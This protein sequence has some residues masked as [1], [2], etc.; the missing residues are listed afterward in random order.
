MNVILR[1]LFVAGMIA[2]G[3]IIGVVAALVLD[4]IGRLGK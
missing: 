3:L 4:F 2:T 1:A